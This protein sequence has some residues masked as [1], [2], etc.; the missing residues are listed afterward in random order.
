M[1]TARLNSMSVNYMSVEAGTANRNHSKGG[2]E[3]SRNSARI[4]RPD[5]SAKEQATA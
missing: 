5:E 4:A 3:L 2:Y 1:A